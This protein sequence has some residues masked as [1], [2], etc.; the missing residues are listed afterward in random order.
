MTGCER[1]RD[2]I[3]NDVFP[4]AEQ[5]ISMSKEFGVPLTVKDYEGKM[6]IINFFSIA[7]MIR[8]AVGLEIS[9]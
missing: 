5:V 2:A 3:R 8:L 1:L 7:G 6:F 9:S 4:S